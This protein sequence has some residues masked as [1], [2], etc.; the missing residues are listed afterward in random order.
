MAAPL[1]DGIIEYEDGTPATQSQL[2]KDVCTFLTWS[3]SPEMDIRKKYG[4]C[5]FSRFSNQYLNKCLTLL[6][7]CCNINFLV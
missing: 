4:A 7:H 1:Y 5:P 6:F 2:A 3:A